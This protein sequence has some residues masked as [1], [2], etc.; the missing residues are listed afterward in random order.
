M[1]R[2]SRRHKAYGIGTRRHKHGNGKRIKKRGQ[3]GR[4]RTEAKRG[5]TKKGMTEKAK[6]TQHTRQRRQGGQ[7]RRNASQ[8]EPG[9]AVKE[10]R[11]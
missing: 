4:K 8:A 1:R 6:E 11:R 9:K 7:S 2:M 3:E 10:D 5:H